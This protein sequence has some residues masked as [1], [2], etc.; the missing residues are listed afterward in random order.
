VLKQ[1]SFDLLINT[2][3]ITDVDLCEREPAL[4]QLI[5]VESPE[6]MAKVCAQRGAHMIHLS[7]DYVFSGQSVDP[8]DEGSEATPLNVYGQSKRASELAVL[9]ALPTALVTRVSWLFGGHKGS[10]PDRMLRE[11]T[12]Q[13]EVRAVNDK[14]ASPTY[15]EDL[16]SWLQT[17][18]LQQPWQGGL[19]HLC[20]AGVATWAE[21]G[22]EVLDIATRLGFPLKTHTVTGHTMKG[23]KPFIAQRP[24]HTALSTDRF[25]QRTGV[26][27]RPWQQAL[28][29]HLRLILSP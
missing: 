15:A 10:F 23:F 5:N 28:E 11:G 21:Y 18:I 29:E 12:S 13:D 14:W 2:A 9:A 16:C 17:L 1:R 8:L 6:Q 4:T 24:L 7:T 22:Q 25:T 3:G 20:N 26:Q 19:L 27:P